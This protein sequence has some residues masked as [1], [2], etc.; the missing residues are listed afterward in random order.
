MYCTNCGT[1]LPD[2]ANFCSNCGKPVSGSTPKPIEE[3]WETCEIVCE[4]NW[5]KIPFST[6]LKGLIFGVTGAPKNYK[7]VTKKVDIDGIHTIIE[8]QKFYELDDPHQ[9][10]KQEINTMIDIL[11]KDRW[12]S[13]GRG[14][15]WF[16]YKFRRR[17]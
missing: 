13:T 16:N 4:N 7:F 5:D 9:N 17:I 14:E 2:E 11:V 10:A 3:K 1:K 8:T 15:K 6:N 12:E